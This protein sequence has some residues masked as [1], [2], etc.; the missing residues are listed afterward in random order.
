MISQLQVLHHAFPAVERAFGQGEYQNRLRRI[1]TLMEASGIDL[2]FLTSP[3]SLFYVSG[4]QAEWYQAQSPKAWPPVSGIVVP[5][6]REEIILFDQQGEAIL[7]RIYAA[8]DDVRLYRRDERGLG[9]IEFIVD[10]LQSEGLLPGTVGLELWSYRPNPAVSEQ[11]R[12]AFERRGCRVVDGTDV[13]RAARA[14]KSPQELV[15]IETAMRIAEIGM[16]AAHDNL[17]AGCTELEV[18]GAIV[19][20]MARAGGENP[21]IPIP[22]LSGPKTLAPHSLASRKQIMPGEVVI[23]D[24]CGVYNRY[25]A[26]IARTFVIG[27]P[28]PEV[29]HTVNT[30]ARIFTELTTWLRPHLRVSEFLTRVVDFYQRTGIWEQR[31]WIGGYELGIAFPPD[32]VGAF[33]Y[34]TDLDPSEQTFEP[35]MVINFESQFFLPR[36]AGLSVIIDSIAFYENSA[37][38]LSRWPHELVVIT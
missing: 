20:A 15:Y 12:L 3:E 8:V 16:D 18:Y 31:R 25:H 9:A 19:A 14:V 38:I 30:S 13:V 10:E 23:V 37:K 35:G 21:G 7:C 22:V 4:Y 27:D 34:S 32:W 29:L 17:R 28:S 1:R 2:L 33:V 26:N 11:F 24:I 36:L 6:S 5:L